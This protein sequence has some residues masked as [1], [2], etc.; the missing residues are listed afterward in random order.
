MANQKV[1]V[2]D[3]ETS[4]LLVY[5]WNLKEQYVGLNQMV[6]DWHIMAWSAKWLDAPAKKIHYYDQRNLKAGDDLPIL[7]PLWRLLNEADIVITQN[8]KAF[9][10]KKI[11]A[12]FMLH[13][14]KPPKNYQ[15][16]DTY[17]I[18]KKAASFTS[19]SLEYLSE[20]FCKKYKKRSH[21]KFAGLALWIECLKGNRAAWDEMKAYN[22]ADTLATE[23]L[24]KRIEPWVSQNMPNPAHPC[25]RRY[26]VKWDKRRNSDGVYQVYKCNKC[27]HKFKGE[28]INP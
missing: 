24:Y 10:A 5:V 23:E 4:P 14:M 21:E 11:N 12:R 16:L 28:R 17:L 27:F 15:H 2:L 22:I 19:H 1:L 9:D 3:I 7:R 13:G 6:Q 8:G 26:A 25:P 20:H 18:A